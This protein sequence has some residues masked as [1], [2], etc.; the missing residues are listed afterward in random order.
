MATITA[1]PP[2]YGVV[3]Q[4][5]SRGPD[6]GQVQTWINGIRRKWPQIIALTVDGQY[7]SNTARAVS[8]FQT[9]TG[10]TADG[11]TGTNTWN[12]LYTEYAGLFGE[13]EI[14]PGVLTVL[15]ARG[16][17]VR[18]MQ[19]KLAALSR[20]Y[21]GIQSITADG[22]FGTGTS[23]ALR[24]FQPQF[25]LTGDAVMG[26]RTFTLLQQVLT[27]A[28][29]GNPTRVVTRY[30]GYVMRPGSTGDWVRFLQS[31]LNGVS[32]VPKQTVDG[33]FG[34]ATTNAVVAF[35]RQQ[36]LTADG[37]VGNTTWTRLRT[38]FNDQLRT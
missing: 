19:Q 11:R 9:L 29:S 5:G 35:Q 8:Q 6:V 10:L 3:L 12:T 32:G 7:G 28:Q 30:A 20:V 4:N 14:Y 33:I 25:G 27:A 23:A 36:G 21:P 34:S 1:V 16:A 17:V 13:G 18:S 37:L 26:Q 22:I 2:Y 31:Y 24:R 15:G 38:V